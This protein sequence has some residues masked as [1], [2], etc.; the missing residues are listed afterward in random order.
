MKPNNPAQT[1]VEATSTGVEAVVDKDIM[2]VMDDLKDKMKGKTDSDALD[3]V[4]GGGAEKKSW[5]ERVGGS[6]K[7]KPFA[8]F[9]GDVDVKKDQGRGV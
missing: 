2:S 1:V 3:E 9:A 5:A 8:L 6:K 7:D 4:V